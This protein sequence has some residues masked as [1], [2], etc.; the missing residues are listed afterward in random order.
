MHYH[1]LQK[2]I[3]L[4]SGIGHGHA[5]IHRPTIKPIGG[6]HHSGASSG[7]SSGASNNGQYNQGKINVKSWDN[8]KRKSI[9]PLIT[10][11]ALALT[12]NTLLLIAHINAQLHQV[13]LAHHTQKVAIT[14]I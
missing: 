6:G 4:G 9:I 12:F 10:S 1:R 8:K 3:L 2:C 7:S 11:N 5:P 13:H 14:I